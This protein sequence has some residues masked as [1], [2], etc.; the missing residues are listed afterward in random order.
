MARTIYLVDDS[1]TIRLMMRTILAHEGYLIKEFV[2]GEE[3]LAACQVATPDLILLD[4]LLPGMD[5]YEVCRHLRAFST[6]PI[7]MLTTRA[8]PGERALGALAGASD[9]IIKPFDTDDLLRR[10]QD[11][12]TNPAPRPS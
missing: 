8:E 3:A 2:N 1:R 4:I 9:Y 6:V 12:M 5:G 11:A 10:V 7:V